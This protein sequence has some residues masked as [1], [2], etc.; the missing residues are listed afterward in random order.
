MISIHR[1][2]IS[3]YLEF[4]FSFV[5][6]IGAGICFYFTNQIIIEPIPFDNCCTHHRNHVGILRESV[7]ILLEFTL[8]SINLDE[9]I[10]ESRSVLKMED[11]IH[12]TES[13]TT[14]HAKG[15]GFLNRFFITHFYFT[16]SGIGISIC[17]PRSVIR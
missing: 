15:Y 16:Y 6:V 17:S 13:L 8:Q 2:Y 5:E 11:I 14:N 7:S 9:V 3:I 4:L 10:R 12:Y 1:R